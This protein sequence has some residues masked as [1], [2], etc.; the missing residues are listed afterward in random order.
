[1]DAFGPR[2]QRAARSIGRAKT[3]CAASRPHLATAAA[4]LGR[5]DPDVFTDPRDEEFSNANVGSEYLD[6]ARKGAWAAFG[7]L[8]ARN[9]GVRWILDEA[10][11]GEATPTDVRVFVSSVPDVLGFVSAERAEEIRALYDRTADGPQGWAPPKASPVVELAMQWAHGSRLQMS[12]SGH[13]WWPPERGIAAF[14]V[15]CLDIDYEH[16]IELVEHRYPG[17][18]D[19]FAKDAQ[20]PTC[21]EIYRAQPHFPRD[22]CKCESTITHA[23]EAVAVEEVGRLDPTPTVEAIAQ[24]GQAIDQIDLSQVEEVTAALRA[25]A[26]LIAKVEHTGQAVLRSRAMPTPDGAR[27]DVP[28]ILNQLS[29]SIATMQGWSFILSSSR[30]DMNLRDVRWD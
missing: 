3:I 20:C 22:S 24:I 30:L 2:I 23:P 29:R 12:A 9:H 10:L 26:T 1:M 28:R 8:V 14:D 16:A 15:D 13:M 19:Q 5:P 21:G 27:G 6:R 25:S 17:G 7:L 4:V 11:A 18:M